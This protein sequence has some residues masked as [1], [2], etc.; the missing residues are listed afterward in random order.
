MRPEDKEALNAFLKKMGSN[1]TVDELEAIRKRS[2]RMLQEWSSQNEEQCKS[3]PQEV[4][5]LKMVG[6]FSLLSAITGFAPPA[7]AVQGIDMAIE[8]AFNFGKA[9]SKQ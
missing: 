6:R 4:K 8:A 5:D 2:V 7:E 1:N 3:L 9:E